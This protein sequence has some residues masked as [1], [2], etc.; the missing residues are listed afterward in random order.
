[1]LGTTLVLKGA[2]HERL[3]DPLGVVYS[4]RS[5]DGL[6]LPGGAS[7]T[8]AGVVAEKF[9]GCDLNALNQNAAAAGPSDL[10][11]YPLS[12]KGERFPFSA[13]EAEGFVIG[14]PVDI[15]SLYVGILQGVAFIE[16]L[17][18]EYLEMLGAPIEGKLT[19]TGGATKSAVWN[20]IRAN[21]LGR[22]VSIPEVTEGAFGMAV[23][24]ASHDCSLV[25]ATRAMVR[26]RKAISPM[27]SLQ[28]AYTERYA[29]LLQE[30]QF[31]GWI[32]ERIVEHART[33]TAA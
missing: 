17:A 24:A 18:F 3:I 29:R 20:Q 12:G 11:V 32:S 16:R 15:E 26:T 13:P 19:F 14:T 7:S 25:E 23:L 22:E 8:G 10:V 30:L 33:R 6:W 2:T 31:R 21:V 9:S 4:H 27:R 28:D 5:S 1:V